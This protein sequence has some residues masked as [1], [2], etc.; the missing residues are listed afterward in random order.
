MFGSDLR[1]AMSYASEMFPAFP[2]PPMAPIAAPIDDQTAAPSGDWMPPSQTD[3]TAAHIPAIRVTPDLEQSF[4]E[5][6]AELIKAGAD[7]NGVLLNSDLLSEATNLHDRVMARIT[8]QRTA[9][10]AGLAAARDEAYAT[11][12]H[13]LDEIERLGR[14]YGR[15]NNL[16]LNFATST[17]NPTA[18]KVNAIRHGAPRRS[19]YPSRGEVEVWRSKLRSAEGELAD[20]QAQHAELR[21]AADAIAE[22]WQ[23][24]KTEFAAAKQAEEKLTAV[25]ERRAY[26]DPKTGIYLPA[27]I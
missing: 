8:E 2:L 18:A 24:R 9:K 7:E 25:I 11:C 5:V 13:L 16:A 10:Q 23:Q 3:P 6:F 14:E 26:H 12:R 1:Q 21:A 27:Q 20:R 15:L 19:D 4:D 17:L 22:E